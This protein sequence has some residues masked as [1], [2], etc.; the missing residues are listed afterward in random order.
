VA[1]YHNNA[2]HNNDRVSH[3]NS[4]LMTSRASIPKNPIGNSVKGPPGGVARL[5]GVAG[6]D[7]GGSDQGGSDQGGSVMRHTHSAADHQV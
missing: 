3:E 5:S 1:S 7:Q 4:Q 2:Y 6:S